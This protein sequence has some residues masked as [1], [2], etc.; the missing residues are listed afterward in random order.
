[1]IPT[2]PFP[3]LFSTAV[4]AAVKMESIGAPTSIRILELIS[5]AW[6]IDKMNRKHSF[7]VVLAV[8]DNRIM[9][10]I[11]HGVWADARPDSY[12]LHRI[13]RLR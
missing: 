2:H 3:A 6:K 9:H 13:Y 10:N 4:S 7:H 1:M 11:G 12:P 8:T 5:A